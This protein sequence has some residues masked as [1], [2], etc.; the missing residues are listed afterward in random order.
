MCQF[1]TFLCYLLCLIF[2]WCPNLA[3]TNF[4]IL[5]PW[6]WEQNVLNWIF[7]YQRL[8]QKYADA[9]RFLLVC[10]W[11]NYLCSEIAC[12]CLIYFKLLDDC[13]LTL[14][15]AECA[16]MMLFSNYVTVKSGEREEYNK[17]VHDHYAGMN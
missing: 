3:Y 4:P 17:A 5:H 10:S 12:Q 16:G 1:Y 6:Q 11:K 2:V 13:V 7:Y 9:G 14:T 15:R 8:H